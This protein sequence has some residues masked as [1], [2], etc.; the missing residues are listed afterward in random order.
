MER[1]P[2]SPGLHCA[3]LRRGQECQRRTLVG[4][5]FHY[6]FPAFAGA[7]IPGQISQHRAAIGC[8]ND[9]TQTFHLVE[10][11]GPLLARQVL[12]GDAGGVVT[13]GAGGLD[14]G[15]HR[16]G[17]QRF[18]GSGRRLRAHQMN[19]SEQKGGDKNSLQQA[20]S[21]HAHG[22]EPI[23]VTPTGASEILAGVAAFSFQVSVRI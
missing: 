22:T 17:R 11:V 2:S 15:L 18:A 10:F 23:R 8:G 7:E 13:L 5:F 12:V 20:R 1:R 6:G 19:R 9:R 16:S 3:A 21:P 4:G 14:F